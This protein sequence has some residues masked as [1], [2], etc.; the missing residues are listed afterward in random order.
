MLT[1][2]FNEGWRDFWK[3][4]KPSDPVQDYIQTLQNKIP[5]RE[6]DTGTFQQLFKSLKELLPNLPNFQGIPDHQKAILFRNWL[7]QQPAFNDPDTLSQALRVV[8]HAKEV[9]ER[10]RFMPATQNLDII[11]QAIQDRL[12][13]RPQQA[14]PQWSFNPEEI[15]GN[16]TP[17]KTRDY[18]YRVTLAL[19]HHRIPEDEIISY[20]VKNNIVENL[21]AAKLMLN[22]VKKQWGKYV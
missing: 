10:L 4:K 19:F 21:R 5:K 12:Y 17:G 13:R 9:A 8:G 14:Q 7:V 2:G 1:Q 15:L 20:L 6:D 3:R 22:K 18:K 11:I 16:I